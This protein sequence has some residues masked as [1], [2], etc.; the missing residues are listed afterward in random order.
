MS[1]EGSVAV[2]V[3]VGISIFV[4]MIG[5]TT[6]CAEQTACVRSET[7]IASN[8]TCAFENVVSAAGWKIFNT[9]DTVQSLHDMNR[10]VCSPGERQNLDPI[11]GTLECV[12]HRSYPDAME[13]EI[14]DPSADSDHMRACGKWIE[15]KDSSSVKYWSFFDEE[16][17]A[18]D[19]L[20]AINARGSGRLANSDIAKFRSACVKMLVSDSIGQS[21]TLA[22]NSLKRQI[23]IFSNEDDS[24]RGL[25]FLASHFCDVPASVAVS[26]DP[27]GFVVNITGGPLVSPDAVYE[28]LYAVGEGR[29]ARTEAKE[30]A[31]SM[32]AATS[33]PAV[34]L[35]EQGHKLLE[36]AYI[37]TWVEPLVGNLNWA[38]FGDDVSSLRRFR[39]AHLVHGERAARSYVLGLA[40]FCCFSA[41]GAVTG[42]YGGGHV[43]TEATRIR[44]ARP[45]PSPAL[46]RV[47]LNA[48]HKLGGVGGE[49]M[50]SANSATWSSL[51]TGET[52]WTGGRATARQRCSAAARAAF[53]DASDE[54]EFDVI[55]TPSLYARLELLVESM[56]SA[57]MA[58][59]STEPFAGLLTEAGR[60]AA[61]SKIAATTV[62]IPG[63]ARNTWA[64]KAAAFRRPEFTSDDG[65]VV[66]MHK[67]GRAVFLDR[68]RMA[69]LGEDVCHHPPLLAATDRNAYV[70]ADHPCMVLLPG[71]LLPPFA[72]ERFDD[73]SLQSRIGWVIAHEFAHSTSN[74]GYFDMDYAPR[75]LSGYQPHHW[76]EAAA[77]LGA[78]VAVMSLGTVD[79]ATLCRHVSQMWCARVPDL[80]PLYTLW[81]G[82]QTEHPPPNERGNLVCSFLRDNYA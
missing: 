42:E 63:A 34:A 78:S 38:M 68:M 21:A 64:G 18:T 53:P 82:I 45:R 44:A 48:S 24:V 43:K 25:G 27:R 36:G 22:Y 9:T 32:E 5:L 10:G 40:A 73:A 79:N 15:A 30:F 65:A 56:R 47:R 6:V 52:S 29:G 2:V 66:L 13:E 8:K 50:R 11:S 31:R 71:V 62:R 67:Q 19:V 20:D 4:G 26:F 16:D 74:V 59:L 51:S 39:A 46:G 72:G 7:C 28:A 77:D 69:V 76:Y 41:T 14:M 12:R 23:N 57:S 35:A 1:E 49:V 17:V 81:F 60:S 75:L 70:L 54:R 58:A 37:D 33:L 80:L 61:G 55:V 3:S